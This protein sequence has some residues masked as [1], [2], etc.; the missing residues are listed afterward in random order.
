MDNDY[1]LDTAREDGG[2]TF[3]GEQP[4]NVE[5][6]LLNFS[7]RPIS[8]AERKDIREY[9]AEGIGRIRTELN[10]ILNFLEHKSSATPV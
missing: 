3:T 7:G 5:R 4:I 9:L 2:A 1:S 6:L 10:D 8:E